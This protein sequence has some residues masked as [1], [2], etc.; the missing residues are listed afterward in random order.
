M[1]GE[2][3][4][5]AE[6]GRRPPDAGCICTFPARPRQDHLSLWAM[7]CYSV[8]HRGCWHFVSSRRDDLFTY[9]L[10]KC[11]MAY[12]STQPCTDH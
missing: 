3:R 11:Y 12:V 8:L 1:V 9:M 7:H 2:S 10:F 5:D 4:T 6:V